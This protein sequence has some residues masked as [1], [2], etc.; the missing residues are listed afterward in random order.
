MTDAASTQGAACQSTADRVITIRRHGNVIDLSPDGRSELPDRVRRLVEPHLCYQHKRFLRGAEQFQEDGSV[1]K[2]EMVTKQMFAYDACGRMAA[3]AGFLRRL[4]KVLRDAGFRVVL[5]DTTPPRP[6]AEIYLDAVTRRFEFRP[7]QEECLQAILSNRCG[8]INA[9][10]GFG[11]M[12]IIVMVCLALQKEKIHVV[13]KRT[14]IVEKLV[15]Y[16][17]RYMPCGQVGGGVNRPG[18]RV[19]VYTADSLHK[20]TFDADVLLAD[21]AHELVADRA[22]GFLQRYVY[23]RNYAFTASP[24]GR[25]DGSDSRLEALFG[26]PIFLLTYPEAEA[27][28]LVVPIEVEWSDVPMQRNPCAGLRNEVTKKRHGIWRNA[29]RNEVIAAKVRSFPGQQCLVLVE[30]VEHAVYL[31]NHLPEAELVYASLEDAD[32]RKYQRQGLLPADFRVHDRRSR[33]ESQRAM[34]SGELRLA[35]ATGVWAVGVDFTKLQVLVRGDAGASEIASIQMPGRVSRLNSEVG[36]Q[37]GIVC[38]LHD[39]FDAGFRNKAQARW[40]HYRKMGWTQNTVN[41]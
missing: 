14:A 15:Q 29:V 25:F 34:E 32:L 27:L 21:E 37:V 19:T 26:Q 1:R 9:V 24:E 3:N 33:Q 5:E 18:P 23:S 40:R 4:G 36:K 6:P 12:A 22:A 16:I 28:G 13:T 39:G 41:P 38:D 8:Q 31:R 30:T 7:R 17:T 11:K 35:I 2:V 10:T 20:S